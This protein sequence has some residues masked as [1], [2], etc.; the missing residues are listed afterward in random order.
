MTHTRRSPQFPWAHVSGKQRV[1]SPTCGRTFPQ[2]TQ[3]NLKH[4]LDRD[5]QVGLLE[6]IMNGFYHA[7]I[8]FCERNLQPVGVRG[9]KI[10][11]NPRRAELMLRATS[12][13]GTEMTS[14]NPSTPRA[15]ISRA[16]RGQFSG[17]RQIKHGC[18]F[19]ASFARPGQ[20]LG[21]KALLNCR[22]ISESP[23]CQEHYGGGA[24]SEKSHYGAP[25]DQG[26]KPQTFWDA[27]VCATRFYT[28]SGTPATFAD[29][30][31]NVTY[32][33]TA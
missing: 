29:G 30:A 4:P 16:L 13:F 6:V 31:T 27:Y 20:V 22:T 9:N 11:S 12:T 28:V 18:P 7:G 14:L 3:E 17:K 2:I 21:F 33:Q 19:S 25:R 5:P 24:I 26:E 32:Y 15:T 8:G 23:T 10:A 1:G